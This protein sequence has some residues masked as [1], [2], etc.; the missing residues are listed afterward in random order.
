MPANPQGQ[1]KARGNRLTVRVSYSG[2]DLRALIDRRHAIFRRELE[3]IRARVAHEKEFG[4]PGAGQKAG[5]VDAIE[6]QRRDRARRYRTQMPKR[7]RRKPPDK[8]NGAGWTLTTQRTR[9]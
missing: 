5:T 4:I 2:S 8:R 6:R 7:H 1:P 3:A 9:G